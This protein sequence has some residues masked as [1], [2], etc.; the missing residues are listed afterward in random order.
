MGFLF[1][2]DTGLI[3]DLNSSVFAENDQLLLGPIR[4]FVIRGE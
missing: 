2:A 3:E 1:R 4:N